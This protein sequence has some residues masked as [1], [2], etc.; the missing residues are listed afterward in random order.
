MRTSLSA[1]L[2]L[3]VFAG[4]TFNG[5]G[6]GSGVS[7]KVTAFS[8]GGT[9]TGL[10]GT[11]VLVLNGFEQEQITS[12][13]AYSFTAT[14]ADGAAY[15]VTVLDH[16]TS[17]TISLT[18]ASGTISGGDVSNIDV[19]FA[20]MSWVHPSD[21]SDDISPDGGSANNPRVAMGDNGDAVVV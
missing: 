3:M 2:I 8:V 1:L 19:A 12:N 15:E 9:V 20:D 13:G 11:V 6:R 16:P 14:I 4:M 5:C 17:Q 18:N 7:S 10:N 21:L